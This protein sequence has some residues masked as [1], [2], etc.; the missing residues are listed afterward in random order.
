MKLNKSKI[1][2]SLNNF[3]KFVDKKII[4]P[5]TK[6]IL[7]LTKALQESNKFIEPWLSKQTT[8][9]FVSLFLAMSTYIIIDQK[10]LS[11][12]ENSAEILKDQEVN[13]IY[14]DEAYAVEG[15]PETVDVTLIGSNTDL[16]IAKQS[17]S[18]EITI[19]LS[20]LKAGTHKV[21]I[22]YSISSSNIEYSVNP[23]VVTIVIY[24]KVSETQTL[25]TDILNVNNLDSTL[26]IGNIVLDTDTVFIKGAQYMLD[27][28]ASVKALIDVDNLV[29]QEVGT[30]TLNDISLK[31]YDKDGNVVDVEIVPSKVSAEV[32][33]SSPQKELPITVVT[34]GDVAFGKA[35]SSITLSEQTVVVYGNQDILDSL[36]SLPI[37]I[38]VSDLSDNRTYKVE[39]EKPIGVNSM[40]LSNVNVEV[41]LDKEI[42]IELENLNIEYENLSDS[43]TVQGLS[44]S[45]VQITVS[46]KGVESV[47]NSITSDSIKVYLDL[48][49]Y[50]QEGEY[51]VD[52]IVEGS[53]T[54]VTYI[55]KTTKVNIKIT[56]K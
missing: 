44:E 20:G 19:D 31:A 56:K 49:N 27:Q 36:T 50:N 4:I 2:K 54:R 29:S 52:I 33:I 48:A 28:V 39:L 37:Y 38:D 3:F 41:E 42:T 9:L 21:D 30:Q 53:D 46:L 40:T 35:I 5:V 25:S 8:L 11:F 23:S 15:L 7:N 24:D 22:D 18:G 1:K 32:T 10:I 34:E 43:Y 12:T 47:V 55:A 16:Y 26:V 51:E 17:S 6:A 14:N 13:V 45:D